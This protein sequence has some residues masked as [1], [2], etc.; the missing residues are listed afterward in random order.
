MAGLKKPND[1]DWYVVN[2]TK[3]DRV[4][5]TGATPTLGSPCDLMLRVTDAAGKTLAKSEIT[6]DSDGLVSA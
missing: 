4:R 1:R 5:F 2:L 6:G 3:G